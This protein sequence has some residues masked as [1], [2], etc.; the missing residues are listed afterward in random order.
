MSAILQF[1]INR[2]RLDGYPSIGSNNSF[3]HIKFLVRA[4]IADT[5]TNGGTFVLVVSDETI[6]IVQR[7]ECSDFDDNEQKS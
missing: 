2:K 3:S 1:E 5:Y 7:E 4:A 6:T